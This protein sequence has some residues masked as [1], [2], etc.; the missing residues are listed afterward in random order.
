MSFEDRLEKVLALAE[1]L[2]RHKQEM[3]AVAARNLN[4][5][6]KDTAHEVDLTVDRL[7]LFEQTEIFLGR[8][9]PL[10]GRA[11]GWR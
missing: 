9:Q 3:M 11:P 8:R 2:G 1:A 4:F 5:T 6:F 10:G 7:R